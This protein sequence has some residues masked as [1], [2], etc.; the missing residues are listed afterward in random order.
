MLRAELHEP[1][2]LER[3]PTAPGLLLEFLD[4]TRSSLWVLDPDRFQRLRACVDDARR[5]GELGALEAFWGELRTTED[6]SVDVN[7]FDTE[8]SLG[9]PLAPEPPFVL[10]CACTGV[11]LDATQQHAALPPGR[12]DLLFDPTRPACHRW[13]DRRL[14]LQWH[15][16]FLPA[17][18]VLRQLPERLDQACRGSLTDWLYERRRADGESPDPTEAAGLFEQWARRYAAEWRTVVV[19]ELS[20]LAERDAQLVVFTDD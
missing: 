2:P 5:W 18:E 11:R 13:L 15:A 10:A 14:D 12:I 19:N 1:V 16:S 7:W 4:A 6:E 9:V 20:P 17:R 3:P 8:I